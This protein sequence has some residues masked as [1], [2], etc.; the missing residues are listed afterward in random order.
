M[1]GEALRAR[2]QGLE[3]VLVVLAGSNG[4]GK[5][6]FFKH[7][8]LAEG[9]PFI[10]ADV[11]ARDLVGDDPIEIAVAATRLADHYRRQ[12]VERGQSF[13]METVF[14]DPAGDKVG[15]LDEARA[16]GYVVLL[17]FIGLDSPLLSRARVAE[18]VERGGHDV[19]DEKI[20][21][22][23][24]RTLENLRRAVELVDFALLLD[25]SSAVEP[26]RFVA[27]FELGQLL[28]RSDLVPR[29]TAPLHGLLPLP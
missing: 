21:A 25:N 27:S 6:T 17:V 23:F 22:R 11:I 1:I 14:S 8:L 9:L 10:N 20:E 28:E 15:F 12:L 26:F 3:R 19:P 18:R 7:Y 16:R 4:A 13:I 2:A 24:P 29:W 5:S